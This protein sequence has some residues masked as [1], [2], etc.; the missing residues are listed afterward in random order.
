M[1]FHYQRWS[2]SDPPKLCYDCGLEIRP[3][4]LVL[5]AGRG[6][7]LVHEGCTA[8]A[9]RPMPVDLPTL[10]GSRGRRVKRKGVGS[11]D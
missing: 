5:T 3:G 11:A 6:G 1:A 7:R 2:A 4:E 10:A 9:V 8:P